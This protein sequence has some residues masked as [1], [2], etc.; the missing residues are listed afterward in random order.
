MKGHTVLKIT[1]NQ[2]QMTCPYCGK[3]HV[4]LV[5]VGDEPRAGHDVCH[6]CENLQMDV[7]IAAERIAGKAA[8]EKWRAERLA[9]VAAVKSR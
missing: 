5:A 7:K 4:L 6:R 9:A 2:W 1:C 3:G 8:V